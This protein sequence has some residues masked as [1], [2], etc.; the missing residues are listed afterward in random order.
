MLVERAGQTLE[1]RR[2]ALVLARAGAEGEAVAEGK[3]TAS[4][5]ERDDENDAPS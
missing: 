4:L 5:G 1:L 2:I 3:H